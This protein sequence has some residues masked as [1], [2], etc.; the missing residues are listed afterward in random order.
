MLRGEGGM[1][2]RGFLFFKKLKRYMMV[3]IIIVWDWMGVARG[4][5]GRY[6]VEGIF[7]MDI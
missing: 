7:C 3:E 1:D 5:R 2:S 4:G 6:V